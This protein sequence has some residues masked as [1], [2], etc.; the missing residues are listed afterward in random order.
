[1][2]KA[3]AE[4][5]DP[6]ARNLTVLNWRPAK[7]NSNNRCLSYRGIAIEFAALHPLA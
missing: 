2:A 5:A 7:V 4:H 6:R 3:I 1:M